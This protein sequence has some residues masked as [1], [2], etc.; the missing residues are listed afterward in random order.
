M[1]MRLEEK[2]AFYVSGYSMETTEATLEKDVL[3]LRE[4]YEAKLRSISNSLYF[5][6]WE[7]DDKMIYHFSAPT[8]NAT[9][10]GMTRVE[11]SAG[12]FAIATVPEGVPTLTAWHQFF[13]TMTATLG[14][15]IDME[16]THYVE[17]FDE[18][19]VCELW[20]PVSASE[21]KS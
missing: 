7:K 14:V 12:N 20:I 15:N 19:G 13:E 21:V 4:K 9:P 10:D 1:E 2:N 3:I 16:A 11:V 18:N 6:S 17:H 8:P 5:V